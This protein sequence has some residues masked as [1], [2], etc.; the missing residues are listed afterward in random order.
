[1]EEIR[2]G[3]TDTHDLEYRVRDKDGKWVWIHCRGRVS[4]DENG[5]AELFAGIITKPKELKTTD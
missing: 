1:M 5:E 4:R 3:A 2:D